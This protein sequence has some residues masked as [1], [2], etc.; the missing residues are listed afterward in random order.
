MA[1]SEGALPR[2]GLTPEPGIHERANRLADKV[3]TWLGSVWALL[4]AVILVVGWVLTGPLFGFSDTWQL[5]INTTT[6]VITF[7][8]VFVIQNSSNR[9]SK[10]ASLKLDEVIRSIDAA[11]NEFVG[12]DRATDEELAEH[13]REFQHLARNGDEASGQSS[14]SAR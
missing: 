11:R 7:W 9:Q 3:T 5:F 14:S 1:R 8:M 4:L 12:L 10:A 13:E 2:A 6:T